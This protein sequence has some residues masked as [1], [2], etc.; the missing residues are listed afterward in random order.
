MK[1]YPLP[2]R[3][4]H[5]AGRRCASLDHAVTLLGLAHQR[6]G[7][8][9]TGFEVMGKF[10]LSLVDKHFPQ[11]RVP[12]IEDAAVPYCV[13][14]ENSGQRIAK[15]TPAAASRRLLETA[16]EA[17][18]VDRRGGGREPHAGAPAVAHPREH[19]AGAGRGRPEHQARHL[20]RRCRASRPSWPR[21][22]RCS[23]REIPRRAAG[24]LRPPGRRQPALQ[25]AGAGGR[26]H[27]G[28]SCA[29]TRSGSTPWS[30]T[31]SRSSAARSR[32][33]TAWARSRSTSSRSTSRRWRSR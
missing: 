25:R 24:E 4:A 31:R 33:S 13:L 14:L 1:L 22:M 10:A 29:T 30:T 18:C 32:P 23:L 2:A 26:R 9:L 16:F 6:L 12:F 8:G 3:A 17:G 15:T 11:L 5:G 28:A 21:P 20:D 27:Q 19:P 7:A